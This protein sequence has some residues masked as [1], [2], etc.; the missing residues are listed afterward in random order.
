[1]TLLFVPLYVIYHLAV[2]MSQSPIP[3]AFCENMTKESL[4]NF[5]KGNDETLLAVIE[6]EYRRLAGK[7][8][9]TPSNG[10]K[11][12]HLPRE[13]SENVLL[14]QRHNF[15]TNSLSQRRR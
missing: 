10:S 15:K 9:I 11:G 5:R 8:P 12:Y 1:M 2:N 4:F 13:Q 7:T 6:K 3:I 14:N